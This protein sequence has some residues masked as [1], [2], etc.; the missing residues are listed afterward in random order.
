MPVNY[1]K[2]AQPTSAPGMSSAVPAKPQPK[3]SGRHGF[4]KA[5][6]HHSKVGAALHAGN[7]KLAMQH[8]GHLML[9]TRAGMATT[10]PAA[11]SDASVLP[12][13]GLAEGDDEPT[14]QTPPKRPFSRGMFGAIKA[15][16][17]GG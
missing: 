2:G 4:S 15:K 1:P 16:L 6:H 12:Q 7:G 10:N 13:T 14:P 3:K 8:I 5:L 17:A 9:A 11:S